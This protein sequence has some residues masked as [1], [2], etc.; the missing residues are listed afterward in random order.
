MIKQ[1]KV[2]SINRKNRLL[3]NDQEE[4]EK[5]A[6]MLIVNL[7]QGRCVSLKVELWP[8]NAFCKEED[9]SILV[10]RVFT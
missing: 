10:G 4:Y 1:C 5:Y 3:R 6:K 8:K 2:R 9:F 7:E